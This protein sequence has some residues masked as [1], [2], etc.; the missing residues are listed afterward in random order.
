MVYVQPLSS[1]ERQR[2]IGL[3]DGGRSATDGIKGFE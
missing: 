1:E 2:E 3:E